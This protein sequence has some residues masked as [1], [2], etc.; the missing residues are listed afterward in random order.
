MNPFSEQNATLTNY[1]KSR[2]QWKLKKLIIGLNSAC[3][4]FTLLNLVLSCIFCED[5]E[6]LESYEKYEI[7][8]V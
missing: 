3:Q 1:Q 5:L 7:I 4:M 6:R 8:E 2:Q